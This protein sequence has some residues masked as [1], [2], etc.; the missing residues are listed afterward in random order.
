MYNLFSRKQLYYAWS[1]GSLVL[2]ICTVILSQK[3]F[4]RDQLTVVPIAP[5]KL[6]IETLQLPS[7]RN[8]TE[9]SWVQLVWNGAEGKLERRKI[10]FWDGL[11]ESEL[12]LSWEPETVGYS[13]SG[14][15]NGQGTITYRVPNNSAYNPNAQ[16]G[17]LTG[18]FSNGA[19]NGFGTYRHRSGLLY[20]GFWKNSLMHGQ[21]RLAFPNGDQYAGQFAD[22]LFDGFGTYI[23]ATGAIFEGDYKNGKRDGYGEFYPSDGAKPFLAN[24]Q[25]GAI[26]ATSVQPLSDSQKRYPALTLAQ[27]EV[28]KNGVVG[29]AVDQAYYAQLGG[30]THAQEYGATNLRDRVVLA[31][32]DRELVRAWLN[33]GGL[34]D[35]YQYGDAEVYKPVPLIVSF[36]NRNNNALAVQRAYLEL[37]ASRTNRE[38]ALQLIPNYT[39][40]LVLNAADGYADTEMKIA[41]IGWSAALNSYLEYSIANRQPRRLTI[42]AINGTVSIDFKRELELLGTDISFLRAMPVRCSGVLD[43]YYTVTNQEFRRCLKGANFEKRFGQL[44]DLVYVESGLIRLDLD[45]TLHYSWTSEAGENIPEARTLS[46]SLIIG[47]LDRG[48]GGEAEAGIMEKERFQPFELQLDKKNYRVQI[49]ISTIVHPGKSKL[50]RVQLD[51]PKASDHLFRVVFETNEGLKFKSRPIELQFVR[52]N[53]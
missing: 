12:H 13:G 29:V 38:P 50:W 28:Q 7:A 4:S 47:K 1:L 32:N 36:T 27:S 41:N 35:K 24:W 44:I 5:G 53:H 6:E 8:L 52:F 51:A 30:D 37:V 20:E 45:A 48:V 26:Q 2:A 9:R 17:T 3:A 42:G 11:E 16:I 31:L 19:M 25:Q 34:A 40:L 15:I 22:G 21:G 18:A 46:S 49:P 23:D 14:W 10:R 39:G 33:G 43:N